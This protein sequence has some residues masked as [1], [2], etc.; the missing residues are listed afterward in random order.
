MESLQWQDYQYLHRGFQSLGAT[1]EVLSPMVLNNC[2]S[3]SCGRYK[4]A[5]LDDLKETSRWVH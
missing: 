4:K 3:E 1:A 5:S 2:R